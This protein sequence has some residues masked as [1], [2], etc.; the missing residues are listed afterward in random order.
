MN[1]LGCLF[2]MGPVDCNNPHIPAYSDDFL[3]ELG[4]ALNK[5]ISCVPMEELKTQ[6]LPIFFIASGGAEESFKAVFK[7][8]EGP[9]IL[10]T[11]PAYNSLA[12]AM[13]ILGYLNEIGAKG[14][15][16]HG[17]VEAIAKRIGVLERV[18]H[19][20]KQLRSMRLGA[21][22]D[23]TA[24][25]LISSVADPKKVY[26]A[27]GMKIVDINMQ[28]LVDEYHK[29]G[30]VENTYTKQLKAMNYSA[31]EVEKALNV[32]GASKRL[33]EKYDLQAVTVRCFGLLSAIQTTGCLA[34]AILN[35]EGIPAAC[36]CDTK[37]AVS[38]SIMYALTGEPSFMANPSCM[39]PEMSEIIFAHCTLP[40][41]MPDS[42]TL[43]THFESGIGVAVSGDMAPG[44]MTIFKCNDDLTRHYAGE[45]ELI[46]TMHRSDLCRTQMRLKLKDGTDYFAHSPI[47]NHHMICRGEWTDV[48]NEYFA[49][50]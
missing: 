10:L 42:Y 6:E 46:E 30:Y 37:S 35:S 4:K 34:L 23:P 36:E 18:A 21:I 29:G 8:V 40:I 49:S 48:I 15:I 25:G 1:Q 50:L 43:T 22:G 19:A 14:E 16:L 24:S 12:A 32:Y 39:D 41:S 2:L 11:T 17:S 3:A 38:M 7:E 9:Y 45:A 27:C 20:K 47:S 26:D 13:E 28:E 5:K 33:V 31:D 44:P